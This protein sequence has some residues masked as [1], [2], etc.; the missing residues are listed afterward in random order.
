MAI[1]HQGPLAWMNDPVFF[2][3]GFLIQVIFVLKFFFVVSRGKYFHNQIRCSYTA[4]FIQFAY[5]TNNT[6]VR[7]YH[8]I[9]ILV[10]CAGSR[11]AYIKW[12]YI[13]L[14]WLSPKKFEKI[15]S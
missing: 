1:N 9:N 5:V 8:R 11:K 2:Y 10:F 7:L 14:A 12:G 15:R 13:N 4:C 6:D 3:P